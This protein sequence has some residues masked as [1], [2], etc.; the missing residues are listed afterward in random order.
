MTCCITNVANFWPILL[1]GAQNMSSV[2]ADFACHEQFILKWLDF[3][4]HWFWMEKKSLFDFTFPV[5]TYWKSKN[6]VYS[7]DISLDWEG[8]KSNNWL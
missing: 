2:M 6:L 1:E 5:I 4:L 7:Q 8:P 3:R